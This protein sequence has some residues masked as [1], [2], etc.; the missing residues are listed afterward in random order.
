[1]TTSRAKNGEGLASP[2]PI[3]VVLRSLFYRVVTSSF[4]VVLKEMRQHDSWQ[5]QTAED[6]TSPSLWSGA[7]F[8][9]LR[10]VLPCSS[11]PLCG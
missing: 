3:R 8:A 6:L 9:L 1:M 5:D 11:L 7:T 2:S 4:C 10:V